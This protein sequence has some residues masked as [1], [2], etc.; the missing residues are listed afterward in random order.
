M[1]TNKK[2]LLIFFVFFSFFAARHS[3]VINQQLLHLAFIGTLIVYVPALQIL[4]R[5]Q[6]VEGR[7]RPSRKLITGILLLLSYYLEGIASY[8]SGYLDGGMILFIGYLIAAYI[9]EFQY[10]DHAKSAIIVFVLTFSYYLVGFGR[11]AETTSALLYL[12]LIYIII[13]TVINRKKTV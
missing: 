12:M 13:L 4:K 9:L 1:T 3:N 11:I 6:S 8:L 7:L 2:I 10:E 5:P